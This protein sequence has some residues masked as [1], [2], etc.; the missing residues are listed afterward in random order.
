MSEKQVKYQHGDVLIRPTDDEP[1]KNRRVRG[2]MVQIGGGCDDRIV[3]AK[4]EATGHA[5]AIDMSSLP[6]DVVVTTY[7]SE[8][9][10][11]VD[12]LGVKGGDVVLTHEEHKPI[13]LPPGNYEVSIVREFDHLAGRARNV[14]D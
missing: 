3:L 12:L 8:W 5:H 6:S 9:R 13:T 4:G 2:N 10:N 7:G 11:N 14:W 1:A